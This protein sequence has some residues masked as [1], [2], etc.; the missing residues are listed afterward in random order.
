MRND[1]VLV[2]PD[3][4]S[5]RSLPDGPFD[6]HLYAPT[7]VAV[8]RQIVVMGTECATASDQDGADP[9]CEPGTRA[10]AVLDLRDGKAEWRRVTLPKAWASDVRA[11]ESGVG[12]TTTGEANLPAR[13]RSLRPGRE[14]ALG[15]RPVPRP[16]AAGPV[17]TLDP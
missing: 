16:M 6:A 5:A 10:A 9:A 8:G 17:A 14:R 15:V 12:A 11:S 13:S 2:A 7:A 1:G 4:R 3:L